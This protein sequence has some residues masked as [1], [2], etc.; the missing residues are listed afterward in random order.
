[1]T[2]CS[3]TIR[4]SA[5]VP[6]RCDEWSLRV[7]TSRR[8]AI[9]RI[10][11]RHALQNESGGDGA[12]YLRTQRVRADA[13]KLAED[14]ALDQVEHLLDTLGNSVVDAT[15]RRRTSMEED[16][17]RWQIAHV[18]VLVHR[19]M[20][21]SFNARLDRGANCLETSG[22]SVE[23]SGPWPPYSFCPQMT[24]ENDEAAT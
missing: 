21:E 6:E 24:T 2:S 4:S 18:A 12:S 13:E 19:D 16:A 11:Q 9:E 3:A 17:D 22:L 10:R 20:L 15:E 7:W 23:L 14:D 8:S 5:C 1:E